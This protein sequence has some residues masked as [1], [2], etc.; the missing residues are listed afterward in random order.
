MSCHACGEGSKVPPF[1]AKCFYT[2]PMSACMYIL[3]VHNKRLER[4]PHISFIQVFLAGTEFGV[5]W[6]TAKCCILCSALEKWMG[7]RNWLE[8]RCS[9]GLSLCF[10]YILDYSNSSDGS[11]TFHQHFGWVHH[12]EKVS[13]VQFLGSWLSSFSVICQLWLLWQVKYVSV[14]LRW[15]LWHIHGRTWVMTEDLHNL[16]CSCGC[17]AEQV[18]TPCSIL[19]TMTFVRYRIWL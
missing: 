15:S 19:R 7:L 4:Y 11:I 5:L 17:A 13:D 1:C 2:V 14:T 9:Y 18:Y 6:L 3:T 8:W 10:L 16:Q 12:C